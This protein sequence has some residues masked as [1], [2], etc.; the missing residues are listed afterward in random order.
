MV[1]CRRIH[2]VLEYSGAESDR[3]KALEE[4]M[5]ILWDSYG[6]RCLSCVEESIDL[7]SLIP[8]QKE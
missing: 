7:G 1:P 6:F 4:A 2:L 3:Y 8:P 5:K